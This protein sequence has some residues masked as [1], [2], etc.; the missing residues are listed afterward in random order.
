M[1]AAGKDF[2]APAE[3][4][5]DTWKQ[6]IKDLHGES[7]RGCGIVGGAFLDD[8]LGELLEVYLV[9]NTDASSDLLSSENIS[10]PLGSFGARLVAAYAIGLLP[11]GNWQALRKVKKIRNR[12]AHDLSLSFN[13]PCI[14]KLCTELSPLTQ[15]YH[16]AERTPRQIFEDTVAFLAGGLREHLYL[17]KTF[18]LKGS[19][20][21]VLRLAS[22][23]KSSGKAAG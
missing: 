16:D 4:F 7:D 17:T 3:L 8:L 12:F 6:V 15:N 21:A 2:E 19:F 13:E 18:E 10:A 5:N 1:E 23:R 14:A 22:G 11:V 9:E 20:G